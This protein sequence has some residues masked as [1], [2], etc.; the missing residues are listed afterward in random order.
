MMSLPA[1]TCRLCRGPLSKHRR[2]QN[3]PMCDRGELGRVQS[4]RVEL[5]RVEWVVLCQVM[6]SWS[7]VQHSHPACPQHAGRACRHMTR[8][9]SERHICAMYSQPFEFAGARQTLY[10][11]GHAVLK[12]YSN[13]PT[14]F[15]VA[16]S[17]IFSPSTNLLV[18]SN[19]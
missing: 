8:K 16:T 7:A 18:T 6:S 15:E 14:S 13:A 2:I 17:M 4:G 12:T 19:G 5:S 3:K 1:E 9:T 11:T 10:G